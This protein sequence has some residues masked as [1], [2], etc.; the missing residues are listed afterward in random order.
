[1]PVLPDFRYAD[2]IRPDQI[3]LPELLVEGLLHRGCKALFSGGSKAY[4]SWV[5]GDLALSLATGRPWWGLGCAQG[6]VV[7]LNFELIEPF[8][9]HRLTLIAQAKGCALPHELVL[10]NLRSHCYD[11]GVLARVLAARLADAGPVAA[12]IV[13]PIYKALGDLDENSAGDMS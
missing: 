8:F 7:Y 5:L 3:V 1:M 11:L 4:K 9:D 6:T 10:W 12:L 13:D 2:Q